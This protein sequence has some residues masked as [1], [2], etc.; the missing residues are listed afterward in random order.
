SGKNVDFINHGNAID[1]VVDKGDKYQF[2]VT[3]IQELKEDIIGRF[4]WV[5][6]NSIRMKTPIINLADS[7]GNIYSNT[8]L[9]GKIVVVNFWGIS[10][11]PCREEIPQLNK[12][13][14]NYAGRKDIVF[15]AISDD[16]NEEL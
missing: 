9:L 1:I 14:K 7:E 11:K 6:N 2:K 10:C 5:Y 8:N 3:T 4:F 15:L 16:S 12:L 13:V